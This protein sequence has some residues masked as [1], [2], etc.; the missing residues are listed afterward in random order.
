[1]HDK[2]LHEL[3]C[4]WLSQNQP[5]GKI[6]SGDLVDLTSL[7]K[8]GWNPHVVRD[9]YRD[10]QY[11]LDVSHGLL[12]EYKQASGW[13]RKQNDWFIPGNHEERLQKFIITKA[14]ELYGL[15]RAGEGEDVPS[16]L[17][18]EHL[19]RLKELG[20]QW[21]GGSDGDWPHAKVGLSKFLEVRHGWLVRKNSGATAHA[22]LEHLGRSVVVGHT[23]RQS[24]VY[25]TRH[26]TDGT[27]RVHVGAEAG[28]LARF[29]LGYAVAPDWQQGF[30][31][32]RLHADGTF[33]LSLATYVNGVLWWEGQRYK[34]TARGVTVTR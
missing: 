24:L 30:L 27:Q 19:L 9:P 34:N 13:K 8:F 3:V 22:T 28:T 4:R 14:P 7:S 25:K 2:K 10:T 21:A 5:D 23:H 31:V 11:S 20:V 16:A 6:Y 26:D 29:D 1:M 17:S 12:R 15:K 33:H 18:L 32:I